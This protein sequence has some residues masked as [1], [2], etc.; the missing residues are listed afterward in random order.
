LP[1]FKKEKSKCGIL[2]LKT[3]GY[4]ISC[5]LG[6]EAIDKDRTSFLIIVAVNILRMLGMLKNAR[7][8]NPIKGTA[9]AGSPAGA[10]LRR[11]EKTFI[12]S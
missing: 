1:L 9:P 12:F 3:K 11:E 6:R 2:L 4:K 5:V 8:S 7:E 10:G